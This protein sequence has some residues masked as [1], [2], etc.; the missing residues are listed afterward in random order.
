MELVRTHKL[1]IITALLLINLVATG[2]AIVSLQKHAQAL[3]NVAQAMGQV[4]NTFVQSRIVEIGKDNNFSV[5]QVIT[6]KDV[7][8]AQQSF[9]APP[10]IQ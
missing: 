1:K 2:Y 6:A 4:A 10:P 8:Q 7:Q 3:G 5:N 9:N